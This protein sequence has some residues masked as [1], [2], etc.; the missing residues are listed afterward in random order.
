MMNED[1]FAAQNTPLCHPS[2]LFDIHFCS[3]IYLFDVWQSYSGSKNKSSYPTGLKSRAS[4]F[5][6]GLHRTQTLF[7]CV[8]VSHGESPW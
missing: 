4:R 5:I 1:I 8:F 2:P 6:R 7:S 3:K